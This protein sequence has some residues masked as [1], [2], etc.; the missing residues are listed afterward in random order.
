MP[1]AV[2]KQNPTIIDQLLSRCP[3]KSDEHRAL[4]A[5]FIFFSERLTTCTVSHCV[6]KQRNVV[7]V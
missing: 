5:Y 7:F 3:H 6:N 2:D 4:Y 1:V